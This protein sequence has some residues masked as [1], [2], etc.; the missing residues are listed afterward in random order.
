MTKYDLC[1]RYYTLWRANKS[2]L[3]FVRYRSMRSAGKDFLID[4]VEF[5]EQMCTRFGY[6]AHHDA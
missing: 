5:C 6:S 2:L 4:F 1:E 3:P